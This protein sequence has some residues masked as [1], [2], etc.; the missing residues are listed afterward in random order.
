MKKTAKTRQHVIIFRRWSR[1]GYAVFCSIGRCVSIGK[2]GKNIVEASLKKHKSSAAVCFWKS[3]EESHIDTERQD[4]PD[5]P[6]IFRQQLSV[7]ILPQT[8]TQVCGGDCFV[9][10]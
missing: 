4:E 8:A 2:L 7:S 10:G 3:N 9:P 6:D 5:V 1:K